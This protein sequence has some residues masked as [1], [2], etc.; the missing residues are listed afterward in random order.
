MFPDES[1]KLTNYHV[2][3]TYSFTYF[4]HSRHMRF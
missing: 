4:G 1:E 2:E 3:L